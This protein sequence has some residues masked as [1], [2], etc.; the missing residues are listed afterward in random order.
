MI[1]KIVTVLIL[2]P[3]ALAIVLFAVGEPRSR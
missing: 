1:R 2:L 3:V